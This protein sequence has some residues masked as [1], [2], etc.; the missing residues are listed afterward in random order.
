MYTKYIKLLDDDIRSLQSQLEEKKQLRK[1]LQLKDD[2]KMLFNPSASP[3]NAPPELPF[4]ISPTLRSANVTPPAPPAYM[5]RPDA[6]PSMPPAHTDASSVKSPTPGPEVSPSDLALTEEDRRSICILGVDPTVLKHDIKQ[7]FD[8]FGDIDRITILTN[9]LTNQRLG[10]AYVR[11]TSVESV[12]KA[13][14]TQQLFILKGKKL[15]VSKK[16]TN[17]PG[18]RRYPEPPRFNDPLKAIV[19]LVSTDSL[20]GVP[21]MPDSAQLAQAFL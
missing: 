18:F 12:D 7:I 6:L 19:P 4:N 17:L 1:H 11:F 16:R 14:S 21:S 3:L 5:P 10:T 8:V 13:V 20:V 15:T 2:A 9:R